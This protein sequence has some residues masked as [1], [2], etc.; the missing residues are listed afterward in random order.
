MNSAHQYFDLIVP[1]GR[2]IAHFGVWRVLQCLFNGHHPDRAHVPEVGRTFHDPFKSFLRYLIRVFSFV[3]GHNM[4]Q[5]DEPVVSRPATFCLPLRNI[6]F[7]FLQLLAQSVPA[8]LA[9]ASRT[10]R[11]SITFE[12]CRNSAQRKVSSNFRTSTSYFCGEPVTN[13]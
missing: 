3:F 9:M 13:P 6:E 11:T 5:Q 10:V 1:S 2:S 12:F 4:N 8:M 7:P